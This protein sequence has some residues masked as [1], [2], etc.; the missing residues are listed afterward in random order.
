MEDEKEVYANAIKKLSEAFENATLT[1]TDDLVYFPVSSVEA[2]KEVSASL[3]LL[4]F[5]PSFRLCGPRGVGKTTTAF[6]GKKGV[7]RPSPPPLGPPPPPL[8]V[9][10]SPSLD[11]LAVFWQMGW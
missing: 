7:L 4:N 3:P 8:G 2:I 5:V 10:S 6:K 11:L 1:S 9:S